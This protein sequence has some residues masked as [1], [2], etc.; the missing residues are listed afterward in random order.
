MFAISGINK[1]FKGEIGVHLVCC[2]LLRRNFVALCT[3][4]NVRGYDIIVLN[5]KTNKG[6]GIQVKCTDNPKKEFPI[7]SANFSDFEQKIEERII[8]PYVFVDITN[9]KN[10]HFYIVPQSELKKIIKK[11]VMDYE[12]RLKN[13]QPEKFEEKMNPKYKP[14]LWAIKLDS[15]ER[16]ENKWN[17][18]T[19]S[20]V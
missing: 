8:C 12:E 15:I 6:M 2:E 9:M 4:R 7:L 20:L 1:S 11:M 10:P 18:I 19:D 16:F 14:D 3:S 13:E 5:P 17:I